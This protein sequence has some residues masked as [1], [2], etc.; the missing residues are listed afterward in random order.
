[1]RLSLSDEV[2]A[3]WDIPPLLDELLPLEGRA[4]AATSCWAG[5]GTNKSWSE[6]LDGPRPKTSRRSADIFVSAVPM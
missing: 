5:A 6:L 1:M 2:E 4:E 3:D